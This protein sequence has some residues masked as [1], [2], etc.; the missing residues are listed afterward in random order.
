MQDGLKA[1]QLCSPEPRGI[2]G[3]SLK[4][5]PCDLEVKFFIGTEAQSDLRL[6]E[7]P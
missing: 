6:L 4:M 1:G 5:K 7:L 3:P 2:N